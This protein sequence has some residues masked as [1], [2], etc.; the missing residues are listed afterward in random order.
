MLMHL[1]FL[2]YCDIILLSVTKKEE[3]MRK[4]ENE[5]Q[6]NLLLKALNE[7]D[8]IQLICSLFLIDYLKNKTP[9]FKKLSFFQFNGKLKTFRSKSAAI[10]SAY[11]YA[12]NDSNFSDY[13]GGILDY[14]FDKDESSI[15]DLIEHIIIDYLDNKKLFYKD[16]ETLEKKHLTANLGNIMLISYY[17]V[18]CLFERIKTVNKVYF[19]FFDEIVNLVTLI[20]LEIKEKEYRLVSLRESQKITDVQFDNIIFLPPYRD[21][22]SIQLLSQYNRT[23][24]FLT[25]SFE[26]KIIDFLFNNLKPKGRMITIV[27]SGILNKISDY[28]YRKKLIE[29]KAI[30]F[31]VELPRISYSQNLVSMLYLSTDCKETK[32]INAIKF[33]QNL[34]RGIDIDSEKIIRAINGLIEFSTE[35]I[36][37]DYLEDNDYDLTPHRFFEKNQNDFVNPT[38]LQKATKAIFRGFQIPSSMLDEYATKESTKIKILTLSDIEDGFINRENMVSLKSVDKKME[39][40]LLEDGDLV[41]SCKG[42]TFKTAVVNVPYGETYI[43]TGSIIVIR[44]ND[45]M[46]SSTYLKIFLDSHL[47]IQ[48]L[49]RI[50]T[51]GTILSLNPSKL[52]TLIVPLPHLSRQLMISS[53]YEYKKQ[54]IEEV[55]EVLENMKKEVEKKFDLDFLDLIN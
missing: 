50:Q 14:V 53:S 20:Y 3:N 12:I 34:R 45:E 49:K 39:H 35:T 21:N 33:A 1:F 30:S 38:E 54:N 19:N 7:T 13:F 10:A 9:G 48:S 55:K 22:Q 51:G 46:I 32:V 29:N 2:L 42:K 8:P 31:V 44:C 25:S 18:R 37:K 24:D 26:W 23:G 17:P 43:S 16:I 6:N 5:L 27:S 52:Q 11:N 47:G 28:P 4:E 41:I 15:N 40:Y 36:K